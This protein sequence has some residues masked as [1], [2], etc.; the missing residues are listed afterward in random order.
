MHNCAHI[1]FARRLRHVA[2]DQLNFFLLFFR[3]LGAVALGELLH[4][5]APLLEQGGDDLL[6][7]RIG[8]RLTFVNLFGLECRL[9]HAQRG[10]PVLLAR[11]HRRDNVR[12]NFVADLRHCCT[13]SPCKLT[14]RGACLVNA[15]NEPLG[16][17]AIVR[18]VRAKRMIQRDL[19]HVN[20]VE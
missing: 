7:F 1:L 15:G 8:E 6:L 12:A 4:R 3:E 2:V 18:I 17:L 20:A 5:F 9:H 11:L 19:F 16:R 10:E 14:K 13:S